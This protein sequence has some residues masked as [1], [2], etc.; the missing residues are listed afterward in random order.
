MIELL[1]VLFFSTI[2]AYHADC[3][4][5]TGYARWTN[6]PPI[7]GVAVACAKDKRQQDVWIWGVG[8]RTCNDIGSAI[9][10]RNIDLF[11]RDPDA[12]T[13]WGRQRRFVVFASDSS[14]ATRS[15]PD[16]K[17]AP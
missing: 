8:W 17:S 5:C 11:M 13:R 3:R 10:G 4:G 9:Q 1:K 15:G 12:A 6:R 2:T 7:E 14:R 16:P